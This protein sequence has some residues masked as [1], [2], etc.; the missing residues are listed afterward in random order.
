MTL[1]GEWIHS[2]RTVDFIRSRPSP[3]YMR[4]ALDTTTPF[5]TI[6]PMVSH[7]LKAVHEALEFGDWQ[8]AIDNDDNLRI[9]LLEQGVDNPENRDSI[10][11]DDANLFFLSCVELKNGKPAPLE[12]GVS[13]EKFGRFPYGDGSSI[14]YIQEWIRENKRMDGFTELTELIDCLSTRLVDTKKENGIGGLT[15]KGWLTIEEVKQLK[16]LITSRCWMPAADEPLD[17]GCQDAA[18][19]FLAMLRSA[20]KRNCGI[21]LR[22]HD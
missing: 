9:R 21:L 3:R 2:S 20:E 10:K 14:T 8:T 13:K 15:M 11:W 16:K 7:R 4:E 19:H 5:S 1:A 22:I 18:K 17:G 12:A 6:D